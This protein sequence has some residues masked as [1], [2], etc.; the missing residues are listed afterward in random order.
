MSYT[1]K[2]FTHNSLYISEQFT[3]VNCTEVEYKERE[4]EYTKRKDIIFFIFKS[5]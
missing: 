2:V 4:R 3:Y 5:K 1:I